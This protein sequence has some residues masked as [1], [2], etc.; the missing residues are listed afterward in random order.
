M[1]IEK[2]RLT[3]GHNFEQVSHLVCARLDF[4]KEQLFFNKASMPSFLGEIEE[5]IKQLKDF[6]SSKN[7]SSINDELEND[8]LISELNKL[9]KQIQP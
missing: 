6:K 8:R 1:G 5:Y 7:F 2:M 9:K 4:W 3:E